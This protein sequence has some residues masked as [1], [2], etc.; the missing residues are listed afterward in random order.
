M[1][2]TGVK[3]QVII[4]DELGKKPFRE[5]IFGSS[6]NRIQQVKLNSHNIIA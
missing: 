6:T 4:L 5:V 3:V 1:N 2:T